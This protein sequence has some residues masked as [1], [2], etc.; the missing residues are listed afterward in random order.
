MAR[1]ARELRRPARLPV[2]PA[3]AA[4]ANAYRAALRP[5]LRETQ[6]LV[7]QLLAE[8]EPALTARADDISSSRLR[9]LLARMRSAFGRLYSDRA[10]G[11]RLAATLRARA[12]GVERVGAAALKAQLEAVV[13]VN[14]TLPTDAVATTLAKAG[15]ARL[16]ARASWIGENVKLVSSVGQRARREVEQLVRTAAAK[17]TRVEVLARELRERL[18]VASSRADLIARD[19]T[20]KLAAQV[21]EAQQRA[22]GVHRYTWRHSGVRQGA[23]PEHL[24]RDGQVF[25]WSKP[26]A[27]GHP[28]AAPNCRCTAEPVIEDLLGDPQVQASRA[29]S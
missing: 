23:R 1:A 16:T 7:E 18:D 13:R 15:E 14:P 10:L 26:P 12:E 8:L 20:T 4:Q 27:D 2:L 25:D 28:G 5:L 17:G 11:Q 29:R 22:I 21:N 24:A 9:T 3:P 19:Q 6:V